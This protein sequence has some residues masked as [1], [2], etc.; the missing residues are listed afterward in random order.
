MEFQINNIT[1]KI[2]TINNISLDD[3]ALFIDLFTDF[4][5]SLYNAEISMIDYE[6]ASSDMRSYAKIQLSYVWSKIK[7]YDIGVI[8]QL[9]SIGFFTPIFEWG[10]SGYVFLDKNQEYNN[11]KFRTAFRSAYT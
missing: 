8:S 11:D 9:I 3:E 5:T 2:K 7:D 4:V 1:Q 10:S 6:Y